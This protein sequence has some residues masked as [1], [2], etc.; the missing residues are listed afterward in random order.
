VLLAYL[1]SLLLGLFLGVTAMLHGVEKRRPGRSAASAAGRDL[2][3]RFNL[4]MIA[5]FA[6]VFGITGYLLHRYTSLGTFAH[7]SIAVAVGAAGAMAS[8]TVI[9]TWALPAARR[10]TPDLRYVLQ[11]HL[12]QV[13]AP[14]GGSDG[15]VEY[16]VEGQRRRDA[17][18]SLD[19]TALAAGTEVV[20]ERIEDGVAYVEAWAAV[21]QRL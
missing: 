13:V 7:V 20:I 17:A 10:E 1:A 4:P 16:V 6:F 14:I 2:R 3:A 21:E 12:A 5:A 18:R 8:L 15:A 9:A 19:G 11:G